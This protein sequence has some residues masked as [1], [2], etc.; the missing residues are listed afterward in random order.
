[1]RTALDD[2]RDT[3]GK[4]DREKDNEVEDNYIIESTPTVY[5]TTE[6][7]GRHKKDALFGEYF[8][9]N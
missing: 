1:M 8:P 2:L 7:M 6:M 4:I 3:F 9:S 5:T